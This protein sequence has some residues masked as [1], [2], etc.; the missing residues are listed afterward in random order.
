M[1]I[2]T[3]AASFLSSIKTQTYD[4]KEREKIQVRLSQGGFIH[5][6]RMP[7]ER[8]FYC[9]YYNGKMC[10]RDR[11]K[12]AYRTIAIVI[13]VIGLALVPFLPWIVKNAEI[14]RASCRERV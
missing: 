5:D 4:K 1:K 9:L 10:I 11:Y 8:A 7:A 13:A 6:N 3:K 14:G 2:S 12:K